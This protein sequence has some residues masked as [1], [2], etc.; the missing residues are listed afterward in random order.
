MYFLALEFKQNLRT[1]T[2]KRISH[3]KTKLMYPK[4]DTKSLHSLQSH[5]S[6]SYFLI[7]LKSLEHSSKFL[8][9]LEPIAKP[10]KQKIL[11]N[12]DHICNYLQNS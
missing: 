6:S 1:A 7:F 9:P 11:L 10:L 8:F 12:L 2:V 3:S 4:F 5:P